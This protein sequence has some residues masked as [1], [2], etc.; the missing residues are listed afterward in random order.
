MQTTV[1]IHFHAS[2]VALGRGSVELWIAKCWQ[3]FFVGVAHGSPPR[4][5]V[6][7]HAAAHRRQGLQWTST[8]R[9]RAAAAT[10]HATHTGTHVDGILFGLLC[11]DQQRCG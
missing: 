8:L 1:K 9:T 7:G 10:S 3:F 11:Q 2:S 6:H 5:L 4:T